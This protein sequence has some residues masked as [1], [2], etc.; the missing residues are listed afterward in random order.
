MSEQQLRQLVVSLKSRLG[1]MQAEL[2]V[3]WGQS[4][5]SM[6]L[7]GCSC[8]ALVITAVINAVSNAITN[9][10]INAGWHHPGIQMYTLRLICIVLPSYHN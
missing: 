4:S 10:V 8:G 5:H 9:A 3:K 1:P 2:K 6:L 7:T